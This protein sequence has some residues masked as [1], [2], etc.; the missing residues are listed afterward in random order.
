MC[1][2][3]DLS[4]SNEK[5]AKLSWLDNWVRVSQKCHSTPS[6][7]L[8]CPCLNDLKLFWWH[9]EDIQNIRLVL[10]KVLF[11]TCFFLNTIGHSKLHTVCMLHVI[12]REQSLSQQVESNY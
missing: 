4:G 8:L 2:F 1:K 5:R 12:M 6:E 9:K 3:N 11:Y 10:L 7:V